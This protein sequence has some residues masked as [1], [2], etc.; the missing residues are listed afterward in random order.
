MEL[1]IPRQFPNRGPDIG[2]QQGARFQLLQ[3]SKH[4]TAATRRQ[5]IGSGHDALCVMEEDAAAHRFV[6]D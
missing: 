6:E 3:P 5:A 2:G 1:A 4:S